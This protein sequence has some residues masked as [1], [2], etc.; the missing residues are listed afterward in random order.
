MQDTGYRIQDTGYRIQDTGYRIQDT[1]YR[2][3][4]TGYRIQD[5]ELAPCFTGI[6]DSEIYRIVDLLLY[7][8]SSS[9]SG[10]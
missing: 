1:G 10:I 4:D 8:G 5:T 3:Q 2:I 7:R 6:Q 9:V